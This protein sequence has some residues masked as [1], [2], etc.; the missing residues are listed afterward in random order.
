MTLVVYD[1]EQ[2]IA[3]EPMHGNLAKSRVDLAYPELSHIHV[4]T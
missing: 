2:G 4:V 3:M 1:G